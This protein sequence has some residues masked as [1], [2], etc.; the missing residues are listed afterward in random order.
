M[1]KILFLLALL[2]LPLIYSCEST[3]RATSERR[4][5]M[6]PLPSEMPRN[7]KK[8]KEVKHQKR[9]KYLHKQKKRLKKKGGKRLSR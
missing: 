1:K 6:M 9:G 5:L 4:S 3:H 8:F 7:Q 2:L